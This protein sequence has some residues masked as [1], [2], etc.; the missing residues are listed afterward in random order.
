MKSVKVL[1]AQLCPTFCNPMD[2]S[3]LAPLSME[4]SRQGYWS[5]DLP[6]PEIKPRSPALQAGSLPFE[7][8]G[9]LVY[10]K[11]MGIPGSDESDCFPTF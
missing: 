1:V 8:L 2:C 10:A 3:L 5:G 9:R 4:F 6:D 11:Q 7:P